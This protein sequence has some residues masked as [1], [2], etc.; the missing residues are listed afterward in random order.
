VLPTV[1]LAVLLTVSALG[2]AGPAGATPLAAGVATQP[3]AATTGGATATTGDLLLASQTAWV[4]PTAPVFDLRLRTAPGAPAPADLGLSV[5]VSGC[6]SSVSDLNESLAGTASEGTPVSRTESPLPWSGLTQV[7]GGVELRLTVDDTGTVPAVLSPTDL[8]VTLRGG[9][10]DCGA[11]VYPVHLGLVDTASGASVGALNTALVYV[12]DAAPQKLRIATV[13]PLPVTVGPSS[14]PTGA[15]LLASPS[16]AL[17]HP[18]PTGLTGVSQTVSAL[19]GAATVPVTVEVGGQTVQ[20]LDDTGHTSVVQTLSELSADTTTEFVSPAYTQADA[21]SLVDAGLGSELSDQLDRSDQLLDGAT[22]ARTSPAGGGAGPWITGAPVDDATLAQLSAAG[23]RQ[24]VLPASDVTS[25]P[26]TGSSAEPFTIDSPHGAA[27]T[28]IASNADIDARFTSDPGQPVLVASQ[29]LAEMAQIYFEYPNLTQ[30][31]T[32]VAVPGSTWVPDP[33]VVTTLLAALGSSQIL[34]PVTIAGAFGSPAA[35]AGGCRLAASPNGTT[36]PVTAIRTQRARIDSLASAIVPDSPAVRDLPTELGDT[37]LA[38]ESA[39]LRPAQQSAVLRNT[40]S[41]V[42]VQLDQI[43]LAGDQTVT[44]TAQKGQI[45][46]TIA[47]SAAMPEPVTGTLTLTSDHL[48]FANGESRVSMPAPLL[49]ATNN[50]YVNV[51][52]RSAGEFKLTITYQAPSGGLVMTEGQVTVRSD[53]VS[54]VGVVLSAGAVVVL[55]AWWIRTG[56]RRRRLRR[57]EESAAAAP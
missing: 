56:Q 57:A 21:A 38:S 25:S 14:S 29:I 10:P 19:A 39:L 40:A 5:S 32:L 52:S 54:V 34:Q 33:A 4:T 43:S 41:A 24:I 35:C 36:L 37:V 31:R 50:F 27:F 53:A 16:N 49:H 44:L 26:S 18:S 2:T 23:Y 9:D 1:L 17:A 47:K 3:V 15:Q 48:L 55:A 51:Q 8:T 7:T 12:T 45:P 20:V 28:A 30:P 42:D 13:V 22:V 11:G 6:Q 46:I